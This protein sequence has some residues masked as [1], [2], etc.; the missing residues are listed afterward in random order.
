MILEQRIHHQLHW[1]RETQLPHY[2]LWLRQLRNDWQDG[3]DLTELENH[4]DI[5]E[6]HW[7]TLLQQ[8]IPD[9]AALLATM[10]DE[11]IDDLFLNMADANEEYYDEYVAPDLETLHE[12]RLERLEKWLTRW[13]GEITGEQEKLL[14]DCNE[15]LHLLGEERLAYRRQWLGVFQHLLEKRHDPNFDELLSQFITDQAH[16]RPASYQ[17]KFD[18]NRTLTQACILA[19][20]E[21]MTDH[22]RD[23]LFDNIAELADDLDEL[24]YQLKT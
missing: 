21:L 23:N 24:A 18:A 22:Q 1:H 20:D 7:D 10:T 12:N 13:T 15:G 11:Q 4:Q 5:L 19:I 6:K 14:I 3:L 8:L 9:S 16:S 2:A 17:R